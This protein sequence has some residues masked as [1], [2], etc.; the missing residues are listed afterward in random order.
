MTFRGTGTFGEHAAMR[1]HRVCRG[2]VVFCATGFLTIGIA[3]AEIKVPNSN[4]SPRELVQAALRSELDGPTDARQA[5]L[6]AALEL[7]P[8]YAPARWQSGFVRWNNQ[9]LP[10][11]DVPGRSQDDPQRAAYRKQRDALVDTADNQRALAKWCRKNKLNDEARIHWAKVLEF[12]ANDS[13]ALSAL[14]LQLYN[15][16][17]LTREQIEQ[18]KHKAGE[19]LQATR[20][21]QPQIAK[22]RTAITQG[23]AKERDAALAKLRE[24]K[25][26]EAIPALES[27]LAS[28]NDSRK[29]NDLNLLL[30]ET[31]SRMPVPEATQVLLRLAILPES[32]DVRARAADELKKRPMHAYVPQL[33]A[34]LP[35]SLKTRFN[36]Y[37][38][39]NGMVSHEHE[40]FIEGRKADY[41][42]T[43][44][45]V[46]NPT[47]AFT[48]WV[49]TPQALNR[50]LV[51]SAAIESRARVTRERTEWLR[52]RIKFVLERTTGFANADD[53]QLWEKQ[54]NDYN[55][56]YTPSQEKPT[57]SY[58]NQSV[59]AYFT[60]PTSTE[61]TRTT[62]NNP[63]PAPLTL[64]VPLPVPPTVPR[65]LISPGFLL[66]GHNYCFPAGTQIMTDLGSLP[67][68]Q[69]KVGDHVLAQDVET[70]EVA[71]KPVQTTTLRP[72]IGLL[73]ITA[74]PEVIVSTPGHP[75]WVAG[76]GWRV[77][78]YLKTGDRMHGLKGA[79]TIDA[80]EP[81][82]PKEVY[83]LVVSD[84]HDYFVG[85][86]QVLVHD[87][88]PMVENTARVPG[89]TREQ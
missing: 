75:M 20:H 22:W 61:T 60:A 76:E 41:S 43:Y 25:D 77:A 27:T 9:W 88:S 45:S 83:N 11:D 64:P 59:E 18:A 68:E 36:V 14:G 37:V 78:K 46:M 1:S 69:I 84:F 56:W 39:P 85:P 30:I 38:L 32:Q 8:N 81:A 17:L 67:I 28:P 52:G 73:K 48:S 5:L 3:R 74:G 47:D 16:R 7:D 50:E 35:G 72:A 86:A 13:E 33:I 66:V 65:P 31:V 71:Y 40:I 49:M 57:Y 24:L 26:P 55:G 63:P 51:R 12:D 82:A 87:N 29:T 89:L 6:D 34:A 2:C 53:P 15:G 79:V 62:T 54:Y 58:A 19:Q 70:G 23:N 80:I 44:E 10:I 4:A 42:M 21:W